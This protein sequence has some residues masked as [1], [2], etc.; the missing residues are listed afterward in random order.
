MRKLLG[1]AT[2]FIIIAGMIAIGIPSGA[3]AKDI[4]VGA[5]INLTGPASTWGQF[6]AKGQ[7]D[8][9]RYINEV[10][11]GIAG[12][13]IDLTV[14]DHAYKVPEA[15]KYVKKFCTSDKMDMIATWDA[16]SGIMA[17]PII[18]KYKVPN[19]NY[20]TYQ[21]ILKPPVAYAYLPFG[22]YV[23]DCYAVLGYIKTIH[24]GNAPPKV[25]LLTYNNAYG[26]SIH[27]PSKE[28]AGKNNI[29]IVAIE[30]FPPKTL[31]LKTELLRLKEKGAEYIFMQCL[32]SAIIMALQS[33]DRVS[34]DVPFFGTWT[35]T[36]PD[37]FKR[38]KGLIRNRMHM[39]FPGCL[40][41]DGTPGIK[42]LQDLWKRY[43]TVSKFD[44]AYWEG[45]TIGSIMARAFQRANDKLGKIN[46]ESVNLALETFQNEDFG[47]LVPNI[48]YTDTD[49]S[50][51]FIARIVKINEDQTFT[52]LT[53]FWNPRKEKV[54]IIK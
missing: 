3:F 7:Q 18:Q 29:D 35:S 32:P 40:P 13:K 44:T 34:Y 49:H 8:Y 15:L 16:G 4:K 45:V 54:T 48:T 43:K 22:S 25:G 53:K 30:Q 51:S 52:P 50:A 39:Q 33:A 36:D 24:K 42:L 19:I 23:M 14:V 2:I 5:V 20:S 10:K 37:F 11:G 6:H 9:F 46:S 31:D 28:Y 26:K 12:N 1:L 27:K 17:K 47:G 41:G 38:G 21:G